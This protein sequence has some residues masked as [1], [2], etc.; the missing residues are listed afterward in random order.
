MNDF[1]SVTDQKLIDRLETNIAPLLDGPW[2]L[3]GEALARRLWTAVP[4]EKGR[5]V[6][7][8]DAQRLASAIRQETPTPCYALATEPTG[9]QPR[10]Y[11]VVASENGLLDFSHECAGLNFILVPLNLAF[12]LLFTS[13]D[14]NVYAGPRRFVEAALG[15][16]IRNARAAFH[17]Y[18]ADPWWKGRLLKVHQQYESIG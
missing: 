5:H 4:V 18:A 10:A 13:E 1:R 17:Q 2:L 14:Y 8:K 3:R 12:A 16:S 6:E 9:E 7:P 15:T 11:E